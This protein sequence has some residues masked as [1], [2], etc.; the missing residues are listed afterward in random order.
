[1]FDGCGEGKVITLCGDPLRE[2]EI[3]YATPGVVKLV[4]FTSEIAFVAPGVT[5]GGGVSDKTGSAVTFNGLVTDGIPAPLAFI[6]WGSDIPE[7]YE[8][9]GDWETVIAKG[10]QPGAFSERVAGLTPGA[11][12]HYA[13]YVTNDAGFAWSAVETFTMRG[14][15][16]TYFTNT[17]WDNNQAS[18]DWRTQWVWDPFFPT[19]AGDVAYVT[20]GCV[21][22]IRAILGTPGDRP[23]V[24]VTSGGLIDIDTPLNDMEFTLDG[25]DIFWRDRNALFNVTVLKDTYFDGG[26]GNGDDAGGRYIGNISGPAGITIRAVGPFRW[27][28]ENTNLFATIH[29]GPGRMS[30]SNDERPLG[31]GPVILDEGA[32]LSHRNDW[33]EQ[34]INV[35]N[36]ISGTG[37]VNSWYNHNNQGGAVLYNSVMPGT[38]NTPGT[39]FV[40][41]HKLTLAGGASLDINI[42]SPAQ[43]G[44]LSVYNPSGNYSGVDVILDS[45]ALNLNFMGNVRV[46]NGDVFV[47]LRNNSATDTTTGE[48]ADFP[49]GR[50]VYFGCASGTLVYDYDADEDGAYNDVAICDIKLNGTMVIVK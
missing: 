35:R 47:I 28:G 20:N 16:N 22:G 42:R 33:E 30:V 13:C 32:T 10:N 6:C 27:V 5:T 24:V 11:T 40:N 43:Y 37:T 14:Y 1:M 45:P 34:S 18:W 39:L 44:C 3:T 41:S 9:P 8:V 36:P 31:Y 19:G 21:A 15:E 4:N 48:F 25:G 38:P 2:A 49:Q 12:Y 7:T 46:D 50:K 29:L 17:L 26:Y 23:K